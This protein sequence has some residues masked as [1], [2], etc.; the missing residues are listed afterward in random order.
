VKESMAFSSSRWVQAARVA[1]GRRRWF[2]E[3]VGC[4]GNWDIDIVQCVHVE[5]LQIISNFEM[6]VVVSRKI[7]AEC[8]LT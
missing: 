3:W 8:S 6:V 2:C 5:E 4:G 7:P 1:S